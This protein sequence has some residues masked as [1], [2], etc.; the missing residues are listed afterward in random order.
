MG[1]EAD[2]VRIDRP[3]RMDRPL[4]CRNPRSYKALCEQVCRVFIYFA[5]LCNSCLLTYILPFSFQP[6]MNAPWVGTPV[7][8]HHVS[9]AFGAKLGRPKLDSRFS[10]DVNVIDGTMMAPSTPFTKIWRMR[11]NGSLVWPRGTQLVW[12]GGDRFSDAVS[13]EIEVSVSIFNKIL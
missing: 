5:A 1:K 10:L 12:I 11:N 8:P 9:R 13:V 3:V 6:Q 2:Y 7:L 4:A